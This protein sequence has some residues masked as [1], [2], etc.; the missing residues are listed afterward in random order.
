MMEDTM[1][2]E[3]LAAKAPLLDLLRRAREYDNDLNSRTIVPTGDDYKALAG[4]IRA[5][6]IKAGYTNSY[7]TAGTFIP[8]PDTLQ[9]SKAAVPKDVGDGSDLGHVVTDHAERI[10]SLEK[11]IRVIDLAVGTLVLSQGRATADILARLERIEVRL[12]P[13]ERKR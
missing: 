11:D 12:W 9:D 3:T 8:D 13:N 4:F 2:I 10:D 7:P 6:A 1:S 5:A